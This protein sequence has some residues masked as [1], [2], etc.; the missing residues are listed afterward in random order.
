MNERTVF[1]AALEKEDSAARKEYVDKA[2]A[3]DPALRERVE[4]HLRSHEREGS[5]LDVPAPEQL[6]PA[7]ASRETIATAADLGHALGFLAPSDKASSLGRLGHYD[8]QEVI[9]TGGMGIVLKAFDDK[10]H[11]VVAIKVMAAQLATSATARMRFTREAQAAAAVSLDHVVTIFAV[12]EAALL[13]YLVMQ[14]VAG[15]SL[16][17]R[18][19]RD[20]PLD[21]P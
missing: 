19:D 15:L 9:G 6:A 20:G 18:L 3:G 11:R 4:A 5:F 12:E 14:Y 8:I 7:G 16:Q 1:I 13:P 21:L 17:Q 10:L 2:C